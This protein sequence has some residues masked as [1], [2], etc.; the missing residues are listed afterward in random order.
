MSLISFII[1]FICICISK[2]GKNSKDVPLD[3]SRTKLILIEKLWIVVG[4]EMKAGISPCRPRQHLQIWKLLPN[5]VF[6]LP[7]VPKFKTTWPCLS[8]LF[9]CGSPRLPC[10]YT[11]H[12]PSSIFSRNRSGSGSCRSMEIWV[13]SVYVIVA[14]INA[15]LICLGL[16]PS[17]HVIHPLTRPNCRITH[18]HTFTPISTRRK[19]TRRRIYSL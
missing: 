10:L 5:S 7:N 3:L 14:S 19:H 1:T 15:L 4:R 2:R 16:Q 18:T 9:V 6:V 12:P 17:I 11:I 13:C 8:L